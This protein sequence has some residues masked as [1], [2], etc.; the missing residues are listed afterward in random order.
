MARPRVAL[1][2][3]ILESNRFAPPAE[4][5]DFTSLTWLAGEDLMAEARSGAPKLAT[6]FAAFVRAMD[7]TG[8]WTPVPCLLA[9]SHPA[10][11]VRA[12][13]IEEIIAT[14]E[15]MLRAA[16][17]VDA[18]YICNHGAMVAEHDDDP[19]GL[20]MS[21]IRAVA[22]PDVPVI[23]TLDLHANISGRM[24]SSCDLIVGYRTNPHVDQ[25]ERGEEA[26]FS[27]RRILATGI[28]PAVAH[29]KLPL[30][31][32]SVT[33]L[34][35]EHPYGTLID[36]GQRRQA[37]YRS[38]ILNVSVFG[39]FL[40][41]DT[42]DNGLSIVVTAREDR[43][44]AEALVTELA[45]MA[46]SLRKDF[47]R[48]LTSVN[49]AV[50]LACEDRR[51]PVILSDAGD[52]PG[53]GGSGRT[54][55]LLAALYRADV[56]DCL[57]GSFCDPELARE[58]HSAGVGNR[59]RARFNRSCD[60]S[61]PWAR[62][63]A[64]FDAD[65]EVLALHTGDVV[66]ER[67]MTAG[68]KLV[69]GPSAALRIGGITVVVITDRTQTADPVFFHMFGLDIAAA[70]TVVVKSRGHFRAGFS[71]WFA[72]AQVYEIDTA[73]LTSPVHDRWPFAHLPRPNFP[74]DEDTEWPADPS[75]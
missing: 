72:P 12:A 5:E 31:P 65:A 30:V 45:E 7:A 16:E 39:N 43:Q 37:E 20:L 18:V 21:R 11:P 68:R 35:A 51:K 60:T 15:E 27:L 71:G 10:G 70:R 55:E 66:G 28:R 6:E 56:S 67:G 17:P 69:L 74:M 33:L 34:S 49:D 19:D 2:G 58:A 26:A 22:G 14:C 61:V 9:A 46:W 1:L 25:I 52:N 63:D 13:V 47:V 57:I 48:Q 4:K 73:G 44:C 36:H 40:F 29:A 24:V 54:T 50:T 8:D 62:W 59:F 38:D 32:A 53:G 75:V 23:A 3:A 64:P 42:P 41:S